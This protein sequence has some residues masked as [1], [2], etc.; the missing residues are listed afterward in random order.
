M[1][2]RRSML[3]VA[4]LLAITLGLAQPGLAFGYRDTGFDPRDRTGDPDIRST[5]R[6]VRAGP[7]GRA[8]LVVDIRV[9]ESFSSYWSATAKLDSR[10]GRFADYR[11]SFG[12]PVTDPPWC[13][14]RAVGSK[15]TERGQV[16]IEP[17]VTGSKLAGCRV[18]LRWVRPTKEIRWKVISPHG[19]E[20]YQ[21]DIVEYAP[22]GRGWYPKP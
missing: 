3:V 17:Q 21:S 2:H 9:Y 18:P 7:E 8:W 20:D 5:T 13:R 4:A 15:E 11:L 6:K 1:S 22:D 10:K 19:F 16:L 14:L 12:D